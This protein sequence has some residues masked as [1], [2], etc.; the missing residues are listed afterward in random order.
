MA[1]GTPDLS[2]TCW[3]HPTMKLP[4][5]LAAFDLKA[6]PFNV[7]ASFTIME[8]ME[9][10]ESFVEEL[11]AS[12]DQPVQFQI[13]V[14]WNLKNKNKALNPGDK[15]SKHFQ[16]GETFGCYGDIVAVEKELPKIPEADKLPVTILTGFL[17]AGKT[18]LLNYI[19]QEQTEK[20]IAVIENEFGA[21]SIDDALLKQD[22]LSLAEKIVVMDNGCMCCT[23]RGDLLQGLRSILDAT[24]K[25]TKI[26]QILIETTGMADP[27]PIVRT[28]MTSEEISAELRLDGVITV[29]DAKHITARLDDEVEE[30]KV[31]EAYQQ[32]AFCD[33]LILNKLDL[34]TAD[35]A[36]AVKDRIRSI[37]P[38]AKICPSVK[39]RVK[40]SELTNLRAHDMTNFVNEAIEKEAEDVQLE[41]GHSGHEGHSGHGGHSGH[42]GHGDG[43]DP[44]CKEDHGHGES[45]AHGGSHGH[46]N[47]HGHGHD[48]DHKAKK[49]RHDSRVNSMSIVREGEILPNKLSAFM[50]KL[51]QLPPEKG[52]IF[53]IKGILAIKNHPY[54]HVFHA[55][56][57]VSDEDDAAPWAEGEKKVSK[58]VFIGKGLDQKF[59]RD[60]FENIF[61]KSRQ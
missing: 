9:K 35:Q 15:V 29:V 23:V 49:S 12:D 37:N 26:D 48:D 58:M 1:S 32:V 47:G 51:G 14:L 6:N 39:S 55:V 24:K 43:H 10:V 19:L 22:K 40:M 46:S 57:D 42:S 20:R 36:I 50:Q 61:E 13:Q 53:R 4:Q 31:N 56:M 41:D 5:Q 7:P 45:N 16:S 8:L 54:K 33:K 2:L 25:G 11:S 38:F 34:V 21:V 59:I 17:G 60:G 52:T 28:F 30:G 3:F 44:D 27:V 18:T